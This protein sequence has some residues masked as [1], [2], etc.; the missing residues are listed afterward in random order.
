L[1]L[2]KIIGIQKSAGKVRKVIFLDFMMDLSIHIAVLKIVAKINN[3]L[4]S[5]TPKIGS[6]GGVIW[7]WH[8]YF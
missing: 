1:K 6:K 2:E 5:A 8:S 7:G 4:K 3:V